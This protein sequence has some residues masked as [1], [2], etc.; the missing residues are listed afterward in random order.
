[1][2]RRLAHSSAVVLSA[3]LLT[4]CGDGGPTDPPDAQLYDDG[5]GV[6]GTKGGIVVV[7]DPAS[8]ALGSVLVVPE[9]ALSSAVTFKISATSL[10]L[11][12]D[13]AAVV[14]RFEPAGLQFQTPVLIGLSYAARASADPADYRIV[15]YDPTTG[16]V[17]GLPSADADQQ[18]R[19]LYA[20]TTHFSYFA[21]T[22]DD[23]A[24]TMVDPRNGKTYKTVTL[25]T[26]TWMAENLN[27]P[28]GGTC[29][30]GQA[31]NC[32]T[33]GAHYQWSAAR[34]ACPS[35]WRLPTDDDWKTLE[36]FLGVPEVELDHPNGYRG[37][38]A[39]VGGRMKTVGTWK[40]PN[41]GATNETGFSA[42]PAG[43]GYSDGSWDDHK[44]YEHAYFWTATEKPT[45]KTA[46]YG[47]T[48]WHWDT[49]IQRGIGFS[50]THR[51]SVRCVQN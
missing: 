8:P 44:R 15:H 22:E 35:G 26:Q 30:L 18:T 14:V 20:A 21:L 39:N 9:G 28:S 10:S 3:F 27:Y 19:I 46:A 5:T 7:A 32:E 41:E 45:D 2:I 24:G 50:K 51:L 17:T 33:F 31:A 40:S 13:P 1:M 12:G 48:I 11:P 29:Y 36:R 42:L 34:S 38:A 37:A 25:G 43:M 23:G 49:G 16:A 4:T 47:R 6:I